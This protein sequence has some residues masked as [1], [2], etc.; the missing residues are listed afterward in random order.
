MCSISLSNVGIQ[1]GAKWQFWKNT[2]WPLSIAC[3]IR[4]SAIGPYN[5]IYSIAIMYSHAV[6][7][8]LGQEKW[9]LASLKISSPQQICIDQLQDQYLA[10]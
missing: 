9:L 6:I 2:Q 7:P 5:K 8:V 4:F 1:L 3:F 10:L